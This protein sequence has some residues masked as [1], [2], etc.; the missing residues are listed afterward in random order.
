[1][2]IPNNDRRDV[3][4]GPTRGHFRI[5]WNLI[6]QVLRFIG[7]HVRNAYA[8]FGIFLL[9]GAAVAIL[10]TW[11]FSEVAE[12]V[13][14]GSTQGMDDAVMRWMGAHQSPGVQAVMLEI[15][16][17][18]TS[19]VVAMIVFIAGLFLWLNH[20]KHSAVLLIA[21]TLGGMVLDSLLKVGFNRP[22]PQIFTWGTQV[23][24]ASFPSGHA[25][26]STIVY[27]TVAYLA[28]RLQQNVASR[29]LTMAMAALIILLICSSRLYL[30]VH[31]PS[32]VLAG[33]IIGL[34]WAGFCMAILEAAQLYAKRN[35]PQMLKDER[36]AP[37]GAAPSS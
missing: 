25:M 28:A 26:A 2:T 16:S 12:R 22:R 1:M 23:M 4:P 33:V 20:H 3:S 31:Y 11:L 6:F 19:A 37:K 24:G 8:V 35:A 27:S 32:D 9:S 18:G 5:I 29:L 36:P 14:A 21:A 7:K 10:L 34:A 15:T 30:G 13:R 17:L